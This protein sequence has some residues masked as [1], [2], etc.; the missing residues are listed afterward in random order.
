MD[1]V[2]NYKS[3]LKIVSNIRYVIA[4]CLKCKCKIVKIGWDPDEYI[5]VAIDESSITYE[6]GNQVW[7]FGAI[8]TRHKHIRLD[9]LPTRNADNLKTSVK[10][11]I[12]YSF[13]DDED[14]VWTHEYYSH[15]HR[16]FGIGNIQQAILNLT[17]HYLKVFQKNYILYFLI[18]DIFM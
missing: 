16:D 17:G 6:N 1:I 8:D 14:S 12:G 15:D 10:N 18:K 11:Y 3:I 9:V 4:E 13:L 2:P 7:L 5:T